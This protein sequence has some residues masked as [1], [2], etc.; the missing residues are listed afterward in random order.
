TNGQTA[1]KSDHAQMAAKFAVPNPEDHDVAS[2]ERALSTPELIELQGHASPLE[3]VEI[4]L[5]G[6]LLA[7]VVTSWWHAVVARAANLALPILSSTGFIWFGA[8]LF[9]QWR[10]ARR[11]APDVRYGRVVIITTNGGQTVLEFL[12]YSGVQ[13]SENHRAATWRRLPLLRRTFVRRRGA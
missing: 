3:A 11:F 12:P 5:L 7:V 8:R 1:I 2:G 9:R 6:M 10:I 13:W 4:V